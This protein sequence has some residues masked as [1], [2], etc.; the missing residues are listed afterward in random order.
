MSKNEKA[1]ENNGCNLS[2]RRGA[3]G[4]QAIVEGVMMRSKQHTA[5]AVRR[6]DNKK[7]SVTRKGNKSISDKCKI[8]KWPLIRGVVN[9]VESMVMSFSTITTGTDML[10]LD[11]TEAESTSKVDKWLEKHGGKWLI[12]VISAIS[13]ILGL[14][15]AVGL[16]IF[17]PTF[18]GGLIFDHIPNLDAAAANVWRNIVEGVFK[19]II[20]ILYIWLTAFIPD[21]KRVYMYHGAEHKSIFCYEAG[22]ELTVENVKK[23]SRFHPRCGTSFM[24]SMIILSIAVGI[25]FLWAVETVWLRSLLKIALLPLTVGIGY[26]FIRYAG[27][28]D[29]AVIRALSRPG[30]WMQNL[31]TREPSDDIIEVGITSL[32][33]ALPDDFPGFYEECLA[34]M[35]EWQNAE[36]T[37]DAV[38]NAGE[39]AVEATEGSTE[40]ATEQS[41]ENTEENGDAGEEKVDA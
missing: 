34:A 21:M 23:H 10:G 25:I 5:I 29:N 3:V 39:E 15:L 27:R 20:F 8:L 7:I 33:C 40:E 6:L 1:T 38:D 36:K 26:E 14:A 32:K 22:D 18:L 35:E 4:G 11:E 37:E 41:N 17:L 9:F 28:H 19:V 13:L 16:F 30:L 24:F 2:A 12:G 31:T